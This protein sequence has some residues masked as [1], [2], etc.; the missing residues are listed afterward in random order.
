MTEKEIREFI[1]R[2][3]DAESKKVIL[4][5]TDLEFLAKLSSAEYEKVK[6]ELYLYAIMYGYKIIPENKLDFLISKL[7]EQQVEK[8]VAKPLKLEPGLVLPPGY[9]I[10]ETDNALIYAPDENIEL[11]AKPAF[12]VTQFYY[13]EGNSQRLVIIKTLHDPPREVEAKLSDNLT[14]KV[15][16]AG[17][18]VLDQGLVKKYVNEYLKINYDFLA[19]NETVI[20][21]EHILHYIREQYLRQKVKTLH[22]VLKNG[23]KVVCFWPTDMEAI[24]KRLKISYRKFLALLEREGVLIPTSVGE[25]E[26]VVY[27]NKKER[28]RM[29]VLDQKALLG[30]DN[31][32]EIDEIPYQESKIMA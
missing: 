23:E 2:V 7:I 18:L 5:R 15:A 24:A 8:L 1:T 28:A 6:F 9:D 22:R 32:V 10:D 13:H 30:N 17:V 11:A 20:S 27:L 4:N 19:S 14:K 26:R 25:R 31:L 12:Y 21:S 29:V 3:V 16:N